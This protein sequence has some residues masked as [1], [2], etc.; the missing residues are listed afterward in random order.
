MY[1]GVTVDNLLFSS[2]L[3]DMLQSRGISQKWLAVEAATTEATISRYISGQTQP[4]I[5]I[6]VRIAKALRVSVDFL[7]GLTDSPIPKESLGAEIMLLMRCYDRADAH[8]KKTLWT[9]LERYMTAAEKDS[10]ISSSFD[11]SGTVRTG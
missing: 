4:E 10:P 11:G 5:N 1:G 3:R 6:V 7:C 8:D 2:I 9:I